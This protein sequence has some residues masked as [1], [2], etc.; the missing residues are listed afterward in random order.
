MEHFDFFKD[1]DKKDIDKIKASSKYVEVKKGTILFY[2]NDICKETL[3][4]I[5]GSVKLSISTSTNES[6][7]LYDFC[8]GEQ[9]IVNIA[10]TL[11]ETKAVATAEASSDIKGWMIPKETIQY[12]MINSMKYQKFI[13]SMFTLRFAALTTLVEDI[14]FKRLDSRILDFLRSHKSNTIIITHE[15]IA[16]HLGTSRV[17]ISRVLKDLKNKQF[18][19]LQR[20]KILLLKK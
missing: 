15:Q 8:Q 18:I 1:L 17:V 19:E 9:C 5:E 7:P 2:E 4:L 16:N 10:S 20:G 3:Y 14:K 11:S 12:L 6:I 13:F